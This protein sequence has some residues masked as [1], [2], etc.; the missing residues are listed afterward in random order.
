MV[1]LVAPLNKRHTCK[2][3]KVELKERFDTG[4]V[5]INLY[6]Y[7]NNAVYHIALKQPIG[8]Y[9]VVNH[10]TADVQVV[11]DRPLTL[12]LVPVELSTSISGSHPPTHVV[13]AYV[14]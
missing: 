13:N 12:G 2:R 9:L 11:S 8:I 7:H 6:R 4:L 10:H 14:S 5:T 3:V 1:Y